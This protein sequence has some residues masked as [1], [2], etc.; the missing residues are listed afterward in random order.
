[1]LPQN[2]EIL[3]A[4]KMDKNRIRTKE[5]KLFSNKKKPAN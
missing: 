3:H 4:F 1:M 5:M 2:F